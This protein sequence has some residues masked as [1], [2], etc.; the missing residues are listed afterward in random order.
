MGN[1]LSLSVSMEMTSGKFEIRNGNP[2][3][4]EFAPDGSGATAFSAEAAIVFEFV[5]DF[6]DQR[7]ADARA[8]LLDIAGLEPIGK[9]LDR[10]QDALRL[11][12]ALR[13]TATSRRV[14]SAWRAWRV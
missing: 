13:M 1:D 2:S 8:E 4:V 10:V 14:L 5:E 11:R 6:P 7:A 3:V 9:L 12:S